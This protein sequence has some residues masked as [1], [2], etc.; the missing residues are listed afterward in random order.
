MRGHHIRVVATLA[1][2]K[3]LID[4]LRTK[5]LGYTEQVRAEAVLVPVIVT[6]SGQFVRGLKKQDFEV[7]EDGVA[8]RSPALVS[9]DAP[10][11]LVLAIDISGSM[12]HAL[13]EVK[14]AVK[15]L[16]TKLRP[17]DAA[18]LVGFNDTTFVVAE[19]EKDQRRR[20]KRRSIC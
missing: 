19:R 11:D 4:N 2:G 8:Q 15:Q 9:E 3:R 12:E 10:L 5:D 16:L 18:T 1:D 13:G 17:G 20:A 6:N 7:F 14:A